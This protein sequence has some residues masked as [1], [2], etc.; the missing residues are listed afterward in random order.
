MSKH[1]DLSDDPITN[2]DSEF[3]SGAMH[4]AS[5]RRMHDYIKDMRRFSTNISI[6]VGELVFTKNEDSVSKHV[7]KR[8]REL[9]ILFT[10]DPMGIVFSSETKY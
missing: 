5:G 7:A 3:Q 4:F 1:L 2:L 8:M 10:G 9:N 6:T